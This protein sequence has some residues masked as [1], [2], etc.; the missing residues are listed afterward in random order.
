MMAYLDSC[1]VR[2]LFPITLNLLKIEPTWTRTP[3]SAVVDIITATAPHQQA[4]LCSCD[5][6]PTHFQGQVYSLLP[7][8]MIVP[9]M[10]QLPREIQIRTN[11]RKENIIS[12]SVKY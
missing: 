6:A 4:H 2:L 3:K 12:V 1:F 8:S 10:Y 5:C 9:L 11:Y 7:F